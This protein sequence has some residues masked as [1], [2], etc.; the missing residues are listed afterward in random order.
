MGVKKAIIYYLR[1]HSNWMQANNPT[2]TKGTMIEDQNTRDW[3]HRW[4]C[5]ILMFIIIFGGSLLYYIIYTEQ[6]IEEEQEEEEEEEK[7]Y[8]MNSKLQCKMRA[9]ILTHLLFITPK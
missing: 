7:L 3:I 2:P 9:F 1:I 6:T 4:A 5:T 8:R